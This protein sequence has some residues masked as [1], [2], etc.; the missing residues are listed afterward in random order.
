MWARIAAERDL[1]LHQAEAE[2]LRAKQPMR[3]FSTPE[4]IGA[5]VVFLCGEAAATTTGASLAMDGGWTCV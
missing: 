5:M 3:R 4:A 2:L 1:T